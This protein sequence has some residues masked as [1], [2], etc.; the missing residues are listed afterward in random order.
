MYYGLDVNILKNNKQF[1][2]HHVCLYAVMLFVYLHKN[3]THYFKG[4]DLKIKK[5]I[6]N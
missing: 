5:K 6:E 1:F 2:I 4:W 3:I